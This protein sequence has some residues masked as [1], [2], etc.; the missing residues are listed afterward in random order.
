MR[1]TDRQRERDLELELENFILQGLQFRFS[2]KPAYQ[3]DLA[4]LLMN[5]QGYVAEAS[6]KRDC[7]HETDR[8][9][10]CV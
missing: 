7:V 3:L 8:E 2:Q 1:E 6:D 4:K 5:R 9:T 10:V